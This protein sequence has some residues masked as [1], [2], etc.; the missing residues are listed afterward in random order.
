[1]GFGGLINSHV[2]RSNLM[3]L[4][5]H[6]FNNNTNNIISGMHKPAK[7]IATTSEFY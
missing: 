2:K 7:N 5:K 1:L 6:A 3:G 4:N